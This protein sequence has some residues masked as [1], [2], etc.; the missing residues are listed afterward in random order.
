[1][2]HLVP[3]TLIKSL[4][5]LLACMML[6][7]PVLAHANC[8]GS[9][10]AHGENGT[11]GSTHPQLQQESQPEQSAHSAH[12]LPHKALDFR[13]QGPADID[14]HALHTTDATNTVDQQDNSCAKDCINCGSCVSV[15]SSNLSDRIEA[16]A[17]R[18]TIDYLRSPFIGRSAPPFRPPIS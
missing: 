4:C 1:M 7:L 2:S 14:E 9:T 15:L 11:H 12:R 6:C 10:M 16:K 5:Y 13:Q 8:L 3:P 18:L 17:S